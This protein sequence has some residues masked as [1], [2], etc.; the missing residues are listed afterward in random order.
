MKNR[1]HFQCQEQKCGKFPKCYCKLRVI[2]GHN[3][4]KTYSEN[5]QQLDVHVRKWYDEKLDSIERQVC[6]PYTFEPGSAE[7]ILKKN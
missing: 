5:Y 4:E 1:C 7:A 6:D 3:Q 2:F